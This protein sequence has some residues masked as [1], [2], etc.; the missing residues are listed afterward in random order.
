MENIFQIIE[1][2]EEDKFTA[3]F[4]SVKAEILEN[5]PDDSEDITFESIIKGDNV[6]KSTLSKIFKNILNFDPKSKIEFDND[7]FKKIDKSKISKDVTG[8]ATPEYVKSFCDVMTANLL[9]SNDANRLAYLLTKFKEG[10]FDDKLKSKV[11]ILFSSSIISYLASV[12]SLFTIGFGH[13][14]SAF[15]LIEMLCVISMFVVMSDAYKYK[16]S[17]T[18]DEINE[19]IDLI[20]KLLNAYVHNGNTTTID[21]ES[22]KSAE[23]LIAQLK[24][25]AVTTITVADQNK[26]A[27]MLSTL[28]VNNNK[29]NI[30]GSSRAKYLAS[31]SQTVKILMNNDIQADANLLGKIEGI[32]RLANHALLLTKA[33]AEA[34]N[35]I[36]RDIRKW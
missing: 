14:S 10:Y 31:V 4:E 5:L 11:N 34:S 36:M 21:S 16:G 13:I 24:A 17:V 6:V 9:S 33:I 1:I 30:I 27:D 26:V 8:V 15:L 12:T 20:S 23:R 35:T 22:Y 25:P 3:E 7:V 2:I 19:I 18:I 28:A 29:T 32:N